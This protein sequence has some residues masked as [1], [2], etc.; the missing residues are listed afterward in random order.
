M[1]VNGL[2]LQKSETENDEEG[3]N[4]VLRLAAYISNVNKKRKG[5]A[6]GCAGVRIF[7]DS[8]KQLSVH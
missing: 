7:P 8:A 6:Q 2:T 4:C 5:A 1:L 3:Y